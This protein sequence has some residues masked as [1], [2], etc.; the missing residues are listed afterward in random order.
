MDANPANSSI[1]VTAESD[2]IDNCMSK[3][4]TIKENNPSALRSSR[5]ADSKQE[6][7]QVSAMVDDKPVLQPQVVRVGKQ[8]L[9]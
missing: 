2:G 1:S 5:A 3:N 4:M 8:R 9:W 7:Q 6:M